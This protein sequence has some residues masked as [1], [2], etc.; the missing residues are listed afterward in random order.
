MG[1]GGDRRGDVQPP[2]RLRGVRGWEGRGGR[3][4]LL[5]LQTQKTAEHPRYS[6]LEPRLVTLVIIV[7]VLIILLHLP[8][9]RQFNRDPPGRQG[10][11]NAAQNWS[12]CSVNSRQCSVSS[13]PAMVAALLLVLAALSLPRPGPAPSYFP[14]PPSPQPV[15][16]PPQPDRPDRAPG[17]DPDLDSFGKFILFSCIKSILQP[18]PTR[19]QTN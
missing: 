16:F 17:Y 4:P 18:E 1:A 19:Q 12:R 5:G 13:V 15:F 2:G 7:L 3:A 6:A 14:P 8:A 10:A 9:G 11:D